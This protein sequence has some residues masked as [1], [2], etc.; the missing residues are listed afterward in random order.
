MKEPIPESEP[1]KYLE[2][3]QNKNLNLKKI[4]NR[5]LYMKKVPIL[6]CNNIMFK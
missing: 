2:P 3:E 1:L 4:N 5:N 6:D